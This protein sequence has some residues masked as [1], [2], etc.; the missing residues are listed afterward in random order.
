MNVLLF[1]PTA[2]VVAMYMLAG[3]ARQKKWFSTQLF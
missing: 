3:A 1:Q 2:F